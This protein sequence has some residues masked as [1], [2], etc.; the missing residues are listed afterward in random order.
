MANLDDFKIEDADLYEILEIEPSSTAT[1]IKKAYRKKALQC[2]PDKNPENPNAAKQFH[3]LTKV[4]EI[5]TDESARKAYDKVL[6]GKKEAA[7]RHKELDNKRRKLKED[8][9]AREKFAATERT[10]GKTEAQKL[11]EE[12]ERL[13]KEGN[14]QVEEEMEYIMRKIREEKPKNTQIDR[15]NPSEHRIK[16]KWKATKNDPD[17]GGYTQEIL[18]KFLSKYGDLSALI[19]SSKKKGSALVE[20]TTQRAAEMAVQLEKGLSTNPLELRWLNEPRETINH[21][22]YSSTIKPSDYESVVLT[23]LRQA[24]ERKRLIEQ[25]MAEDNET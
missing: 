4:L 17:N 1:D 12:I 2:H 24:E 3:Q 19:M 22:V 25:M 18:S 21:R 9:E 10:T 5:L 6:R 23:K 20:F 11:K 7:Q 8:L 16:I 14:K 13:R 15:W